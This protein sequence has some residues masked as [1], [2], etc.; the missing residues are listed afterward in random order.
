MKKAFIVEAGKYD[1][2]GDESISYSSVSMT[3]I[4]EAV[5]D[6]KSCLSYPWVRLVVLIDGKEVQTFDRYTL[7]M[8]DLI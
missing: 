5:A 1:M 6:V 7:A 2:E 3:G 4:K 8:L